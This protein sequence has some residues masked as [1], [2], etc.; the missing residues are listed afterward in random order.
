MLKRQCSHSTHSRDMQGLR[1]KIQQLWAL[2]HAN[3]KLPEIYYQHLPHQN[4]SNSC[5]FSHM[6]GPPKPEAKPNP[7]GQH[8]FLI[9]R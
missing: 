3:F 9:D 6:V 7:A 5:A 4:R 2:R 8:T 1:L